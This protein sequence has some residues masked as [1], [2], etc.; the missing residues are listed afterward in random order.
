MNGSSLQANA[1]F[2][3][4]EAQQLSQMLGIDQHGMSAP[5]DSTRTAQAALATPMQSSSYPEPSSYQG[6]PGMPQGYDDTPGSAAAQAL[7]DAAGQRSGSGPK[8]QVGSEEWHQQRKDNHK[9]GELGPTLSG[10]HC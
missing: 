6:T 9:E 1:D 10:N 4:T 3:I 8:P 7:Y 5:D 2:T